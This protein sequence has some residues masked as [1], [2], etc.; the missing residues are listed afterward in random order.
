MKNNK[1]K[2]F[3]FGFCVF[4]G[5]VCI[6]V[7]SM[8]SFL[9]EFTENNDVHCFVTTAR[10][11]LRGDVL[12]QDVYE[13]KGPLLYFLYVIGLLI[14]SDSFIGISIV[15]TV[16]YV[17]YIWSM[18]KIAE[19][20]IE[21]KFFRYVV[22]VF[23][24]WISCSDIAFDGGG[25]CEEFALPFICITMYIVLK[26]FKREYPKNIRAIDVIIIGFCFACVFWMKYSLVGT[27]FGLVLLIIIYQIKD[28]KIKMIWI[29]MLEFLL[30]VFV[31]TLPVL[32][33]YG[34]NGGIESL[35]DVYFYKLLFEYSGGDFYKVS[36]LDSFFL[37][38]YLQDHMACT[39]CYIG[40][41]LYCLG[42]KEEHFN[43]NEKVAIITL[44]ITGIAV[45]SMTY[46]WY[47]STEY[48]CAFSVLGVI[49]AY[50]MIYDNQ[51]KFRYCMDKIMHIGY[52]VVTKGYDKTGYYALLAGGIIAVINPEP[53]LSVV[54]LAL[55]VILARALRKT[56]KIKRLTGISVIFIKYIPL[57]ILAFSSYTTMKISCVIAIILLLL[58]DICRHKEQFVRYVDKGIEIIKSIYKNRRFVRGLL[59]FM[60]CV[61]IIAYTMCIS[62]YSRFI[63]DDTEYYPQYRIAEY[64]NNGDIED[65]KIIYWNCFDLGIYWLTD[66]Y[67]PYKYFCFYN[68]DSD[69]IPNL[70][71]EGMESGYIDYVVSTKGLPS[72]NDDF[73][74]VYQGAR[75]YRNDNARDYY[76][77]KRKTDKN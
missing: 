1:E 52:N 22:T 44:I 57:I 27:Y 4:L 12:Y 70:F 24:A 62:K 58:Y 67:P 59:G 13:H 21:S 38:N 41:V 34:I 55:G 76:L 25:Q 37:E 40:T 65:P 28:K 32:I 3:L 53:F 42:R 26:Y 73:E 39:A 6:A 20:Y 23:A 45:K 69:Y 46:N 49:V 15:E 17:V 36:F 29:Y 11:M 72:A 14:D 9:Y 7:N 16:F 10:C 19:L 66:T 31:G 54:K 2:I 64:I 74:L 68:L 56:E 60:I 8:N 47:Y 18:Y 61:G 77:Y 50:M 30:G 43:K 33:Y 5:I 48:A 51:S 63:M 71:T 75:E 35:F